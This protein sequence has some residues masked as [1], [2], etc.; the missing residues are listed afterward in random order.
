MRNK[1]NKILALA[2]AFMMIFSVV[3]CQEEAEPTE[4]PESEPTEAVAPATEE[5]T[6]E[7]PATEKPTVEEPAKAAVD[8]DAL[9]AELKG[10][11]DWDAYNFFMDLQNRGLSSSEILTFFINI[12]LSDANESI[13]K[14]YTEDGLGMFTEDYPHGATYGD[15]VFEVGGGTEIVGP[16]TGNNEKLPLTDYVPIPAGTVGDPNTTYV[17]GAQVGNSRHPWAAALADSFLWAGEQ[18]SN[19]K[20][21]YNEVA[22]DANSYAEIIDSLIAQDVDVIVVHPARVAVGASTA[23]KAEEAGIP[24]V[25]VDLVTTYQEV[26]A[27]VAGNFDANGTQVALKVIQQ[28]ADEGSFDANMVMLRKPLGSTAD[29]IRTGNFLKVLSYFP[30]IVHLQSYHDENIRTEALANVEAALQ[31]YPD[32]DIIYGS[33]DHEAIVAYEASVA[34]NRLNSREGGKKIIIPCIDDSAEA[35]SLM[36]QGAF[37]VL[38]PYPPLVAD[39]AMR[40]AIKIAIGEEVPQD[41]VIPPLPVITLD[42]A[43]L[44][45]I[46]T[47][48]SETWDQYSFGKDV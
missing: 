29:A 18:Y 36:K 42:G 43:P 25:T 2:L 37:E 27:R 17:I 30:N 14:V 35:L 13:Y 19:V 3:G 48:T 31:T 40:V 10:K 6:A 4:A 12:P 45:G 16:F 47:M 26:T 20:V 22:A 7:Q 38:A 39:I 21:V 8:Y 23:Q 1:W 11:T 34:A 15:Y 9:Y 5:P 32:I 33:G 24:V 28:L 41:I 46:E 44:F